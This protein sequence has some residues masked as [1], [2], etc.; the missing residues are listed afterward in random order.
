MLS[1]ERPAQTSVAGI[2]EQVTPQMKDCGYH[3]PVQGSAGLLRG[4]SEVIEVLRN[5][6]EVLVKNHTEL[7]NAIELFSLQ[8]TLLYGSFFKKHNMLNQTQH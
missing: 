6:A 7:L 4:C 1:G 3:E 8:L 5:H 2:P